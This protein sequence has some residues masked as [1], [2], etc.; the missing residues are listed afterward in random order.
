MTT[1]QQLQTG[2]Q[3]FFSLLLIGGG[4]LLLL[5][6]FDLLDLGPVWRLW[7][8]I[9]VALGIHKVL[10]VNRWTKIGE[11]VWW[12]FLGLW[13]HVSFNQVWDLGFRDTWP[14]LIVAWGISILW[15]SFVKESHHRL[16]QEKGN[17]N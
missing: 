5:H 3:I 11:G 14:L 17:G 2:T 12:I 1:K 10:Q 6:N 15:N 13:L 9:L 4:L 16:A 7:P 8:F